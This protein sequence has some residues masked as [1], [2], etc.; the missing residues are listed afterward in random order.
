MLVNPSVFEGLI[1][2][3]GFP[4]PLLHRF[5]VLETSPS[6]GEGR[7]FLFCGGSAAIV[8]H[9]A[10]PI[11]SPSC[12]RRAVIWIVRLVPVKGVLPVVAAPRFLCVAPLEHVSIGPACACACRRFAI[13]QVISVDLLFPPCF[14]FLEYEKCL[15]IRSRF[16]LL[17]FF[18]L[19]SALRLFS[20]RACL[21]F[22]NLRTI[23]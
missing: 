9:G 20:S 23:R 6:V 5:E 16:H 2:F 1:G 10:P 12:S 21:R 17:N 19:T 4:F 14:I 22:K 15:P 7:A 3:S 11:L 18:L 13:R 8:V